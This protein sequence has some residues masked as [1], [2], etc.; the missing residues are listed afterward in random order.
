[1]SKVT[2]ACSPLVQLAKKY[3][4]DMNKDDKDAAKKFTEIGEAYEVLGDEEKRKHYDM[5]GQSAFTGRGRAGPGA[6]AHPF[7]QMRA[8]EIF[9]EFFR[10]FGGGG[11]DFG[12][13][14]FNFG[15]SHGGDPFAHTSTP[16]EV[17][18]EKYGYHYRL[19]GLTHTHTHSTHTCMHMH[20]HTHTHTHTHAR[21]HAHT[22]T[23]TTSLLLSKSTDSS[24][25]R[26]GSHRHDRMQ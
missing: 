3:H 20:T 25:P 7:T 22:H 5:F 23:C 12:N 14:G 4:P 1:M 26:K 9:K 11:S 19:V 6:G 8:E 17:R 16:Q 2:K 10:S 18:M 24:L 21:T 15:S 13:L